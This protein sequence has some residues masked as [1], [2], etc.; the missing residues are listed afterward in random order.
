MFRNYLKTAI[1]NL[2][3][4][5]LYAIINVLGMAVGIAACLLI[6]LVIQFETSFDNFHPNKAQIY[7]IGT[8][9]HNQDG[10]SYSDGIA[11]PAAPA[12][13]I[14]F[15]EIKQVARIFKDGEDQVTLEPT[16]TAEI[17]KFKENFYFADSEFFELF[18]VPMLAGNM[19]AALSEPHSAIVTQA[20]AEKYFGDW[21]SAIGK[22]LK[23]NNDDKQIF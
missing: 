15:P 23:R 1:R 8:E 4:N 12:M 22:T 2:K 16:A 6:F 10:I 17:K 13:R 14:D 5:K 21:K 3:R 9:F 11:F 19:R 20:I 7:R 18:N